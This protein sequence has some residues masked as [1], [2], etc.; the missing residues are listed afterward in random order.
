M[1]HAAP[2][3]PNLFVNAT[4]LDQLRVKLKTEPWRAKLLEQVREDAG[5]GNPVAGAVVYALTGDLASGTKVRGQLV[6]QAREF[7]PGRRDAQYPWGPEAGAA[8]AYDL[9]AP[10]LPAGEQQEVAGFLRRLALEAIKY[11]QGQPLTPNMSFVCHW[12]IGLIGYAIADSEIIEWAV[13]DPGPESAWPLGRIQAAHRARV[14][15][16]RLLG[17]SSHL[18]ELQP[19]GNDVSGGGRPAPRW[20]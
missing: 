18:R 11:H 10:L 8:I 4:E 1:L 17:R 9:V 19:P 12:R 7:V 6:R 16:R 15:R 14:D 5:A 2:Q 20:H 3:H 13:N